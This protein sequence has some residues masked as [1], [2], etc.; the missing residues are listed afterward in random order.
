VKVTLLCPQS[1]PVLQRPGKGHTFLKKG[2]IPFQFQLLPLESNSGLPVCAQAS[3]SNLEGRSKNIPLT[4]LLPPT[5]F[6]ANTIAVLF[7]TA[8]L[9]SDE[10]SHVLASPPPPPQTVTGGSKM[11]GAY[12]IWPYSITRTVSKREGSAR[13]VGGAEESMAEPTLRKGLGKAVCDGQTGSPATCNH[14]IVAIA[15][16]ADLALDLH[17]R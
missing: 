17:V 11:P 16:L 7:F 14:K 6:P 5:A 12:S 4:A 15:E 10:N 1:A 3:K 9:G 2:K 8:G 13:R